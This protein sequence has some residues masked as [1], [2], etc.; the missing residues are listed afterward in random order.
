M[1]ARRL[2]LPFCPSLITA[3][4][5]KIPINVVSL[6]DEGSSFRTLLFSAIILPRMV[7]VHGFASLLVITVFLSIYRATGFRNPHVT[8]L[9]GS[10]NIQFIN[11]DKRTC[12]I[13]GYLPQLRSSNGQTTQLSLFARSSPPLPTQSWIVHLKYIVSLLLYSSWQ[14]KLIWAIHLVIIYKAGQYLCT[15]ENVQSMRNML[16]LVNGRGTEV[17]R[18]IQEGQTEL[19]RTFQVITRVLLALVIYP[20]TPNLVLIQL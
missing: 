12:S 2:L 8:T 6:F 15:E 5:Y 20:S 11:Q 1:I 10:R 4:P 14:R 13:N 3:A 7:Q 18:I 17:T 16:Q 19:N 9:I